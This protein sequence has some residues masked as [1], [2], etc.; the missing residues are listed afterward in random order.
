MK[1]YFNNPELKKS[2]TVFLVV[3]IIFLLSSYIII[4]VN[5]ERLKRDYLEV[6]GSI[7]ARMVKISPHM[8][9]EI[10]PL[11]VG[12]LN[13][14][15]AARGREILRQYGLSES[16][17]NNLFPHVNQSFSNNVMSILF[18]GVLLTILLF[19]LNYLQYGYFYR[20]M[21]AFSSAA[22]KIVEGDYNL[23]LS[24]EKEGDLSKLTKSFNSMG[25]VIRANI[26]ALKKEKVFL[27]NLLSD[28][29]H[30]LK[31]PLSSMILY[32]D[33]L[34]NRNPSREQSRTFLINSQNQLNRMQWLIQNLLKL[35]KIDA[36]AIE[37]DIEDQSLN[38][39]I[40][41]VVE[42]LESKAQEKKV[43]VEFIQK[44]NVLLKH[45]RLWLQEALINVVK[46]SIE[47]SKEE[48]A[49]TI[50]LEENPVF[51]RVT[52]EDKGEG[53]DEVDLCNIFRRFYKGKSS[54]KTD[55]IG[56]GLALAKSI[57]EKHGGYIEAQSRIGEGTRMIMTFLK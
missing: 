27:V 4:S 40:E 57:I 46:N 29:S 26:S 39:T 31:T 5:N 12:E 56:I 30:Q 15:E 18:A 11:V 45:D 19:T 14:E 36:D 1:G 38:E 10:V 35:A 37:L 42:I 13:Q 48:G 9:K 34:I 6:L 49:V 54:P 24:E 47:H 3:M 28:I 7:T 44:V 55:S 2:S 16:L 25:E 22:K 41:E 50:A 52:V 8:E 21:R 51:T 43:N 17:E 20:N 33:I 53:I 32:N 23:K